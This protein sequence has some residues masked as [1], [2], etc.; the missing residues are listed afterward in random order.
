M[1][2]KRLQEYLELIE[3]LINSSS[4]EELKKILTDNLEL[5][6]ASF[7]QTLEA[8]VQMKSDD[9]DEDTANFLRAV[10]NVLTEALGLSPT[11]DIKQSLESLKQPEF[12]PYGQFLAEV[13]QA[14][15]ESE[16]REQRIQVVYPLLKA[17]I[18]KLDANLADVL[19]RWATSFFKAAEA[20]EAESIGFAI[21]SFSILIKNF[22]LGNKANNMEIAITGYEVILTIFTKDTSPGIWATIQN[23]LGIAY[24]DRIKGDKADNIEKAI[25][26]YNAA[27]EI[28]TRKDF[29]AYW[30]D[31]QNNL[32]AAYSD[33]IKGDK[34][35]NIEKAIAAYN[36][37][38]E[39]YTRN[40][41]P[42]YW[43][44]TQN[45]LGN[46]YSDRI[47][48]DK[49]E[50]IEKVIAAYNAALEIYTRNDFPQ[51]WAN[52]QNNLGIAYSDRIK[53]DKA[54]NIEKAIAA[55]NAALEIRI[56]TALPIDCLQTAYYLGKLLF[57]IKRWQ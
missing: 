50:N 54:D 20:E 36:A 48:G 21:G 41:F 3:K 42:Q 43:A 57:E 4:D 25:A 10:A 15:D 40:D 52:T 27:L 14:I 47:K 46:A 23:N 45:N 16:N 31:T 29:P 18:D 12:Q 38:L 44:M 55:Y 7:L 9:G 2:E 39:I 28:R 17:N 26:A 13:L 19:R 11:V 30:A 32:G 56:P 24:S 37:A 22:P 1:D 6:D 33:R 53:G 51:Y 5:L 34:A 49:A 8:A 35:E